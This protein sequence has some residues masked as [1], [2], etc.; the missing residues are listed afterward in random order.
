M[1]VVFSATYLSYHG[2]RS[3]FNVLESL[4]LHNRDRMPEF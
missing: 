2:M 1:L 4:E 3:R